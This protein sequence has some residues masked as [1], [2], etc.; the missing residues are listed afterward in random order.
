MGG[1]RQILAG[2]KCPFCPGEYGDGLTFVIV[3]G[4]K[5]DPE[6]VVGL[7]VDGVTREDG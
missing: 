3:E 5:R 6:R 7:R 2:E 1:D 4:A